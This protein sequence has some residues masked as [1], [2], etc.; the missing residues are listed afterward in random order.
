MG[1]VLAA[2]G[3]ALY[4]TLVSYAQ[5]ANN[6]KSNGYVLTRYGGNLSAKGVACR[7]PRLSVVSARSYVVIRAS[8][9][10][11][12]VECVTMQ[13]I[14]LHLLEDV[15]GLEPACL[16]RRITSNRRYMAKS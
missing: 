3:V 8:S 13:T 6:D 14:K 15:D 5:L 12:R 4:N 1:C 9:K 7:P 10:P 16:C 2:T 11:T